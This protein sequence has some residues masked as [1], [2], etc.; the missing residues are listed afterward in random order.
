MKSLTALPSRRNSDW[1]RRPHGRALHSGI[2]IS[3]SARENGAADDDG[4][5]LGAGLPEFA[6][7]PRNTLE[8]REAQVAVGFRRVPTQSS[9]TSASDRAAVRS[10]C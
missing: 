8:L 10:V 3:R 5:R 6:R 1:R 7:S 9:A 2:T 4:Q